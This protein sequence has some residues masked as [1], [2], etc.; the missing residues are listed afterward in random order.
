MLN[1]TTVYQNYLRWKTE[2]LAERPLLSV[3][4][5]AYNEANR[6][7]PTIGAMAA[8]CSSLGFPWELIIAD[9]GSKDN[10]VELI[11]GLGLVNLRLLVAERNGG[12][13]RAVQR[14]ML[15]ARGEYILFADADNSTPIEE[16]E[17]LLQKMT[18]GYDVVIGSR[19]AEGAQEANRSLLRR[20][21]SGGLRGLVRG[22]MGLGFSDTQCGFKLFRRRV[23]RS[24]CQRQT[25]MGFSFDLELLYLAVRFGYQ[26]AEE[27]VTWV[28][29]PGSKVETTKEIQ[30]FL[31]D[32]MKIRLNDL[33]G[34]YDLHTEE[35]TE[36]FALNHL[37]LQGV[38]R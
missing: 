4:I 1:S 26:V 8:Y 12:K 19:A 18:E 28:D 7:V 33:R 35:E 36:H 24:L 20:M 23:A 17:D 29:A 9:D 11:R 10:T 27:P 13:G 6:I 38:E 34:F 5:P 3:V 25:I 30:R 2:P 14:G 15:A 22:F 37:E 32:L 16:L 31:R 21:M